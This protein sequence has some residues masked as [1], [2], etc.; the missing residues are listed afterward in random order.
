MKTKI[1][2]LAILAS[3]LMVACDD[4][5][6]VK[7]SLMYVSVKYPKGFEDKSPKMKMATFVLENVNTGEKTTR[8]VYHSP[9]SYFNVEDGI[10]NMSVEGKM[11][12]EV[13]AAEGGFVKKVADVRSKGENI[14]VVGGNFDLPMQFFLHNPSTGFVISEIY[15]TGSKTPDGK[16]Y[17]GDKFIEI[18][19]NSNETLYADGLCIAET[20]LNTAMSLNEYTPDIR[21]EATPVSSVY[22]IPGTGREHP[23]KPGETI[24]L[25]DIG[26]DH[27]TQNQNAID[28]SKADF[29]WYDKNDNY[30]DP[31]T[32]EVPNME[33][34]VSTSESVWSL[35]NRGYTGYVLFRPKTALTSEQF[36]AEYAYHYKYHFVMGDF[37]KWM[38]FDAWKAPNEW[39]I[40]A[41]QCST[42]SAFEWTV[43]SPELDLTW[44]H[45]GDSNDERYGHSVKRKIGSEE[46]GRIV[47]QDTNDSASDFIST[48]PNPSPG[49]VADHT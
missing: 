47:L 32:P 28:L 13:K 48:A 12:Y 18:Y 35:H 22:R 2:M 8:E 36:T 1:L 23:V 7:E 42:P 17:D 3:L 15:F 10:Y 21:K 43:M 29:E 20:E 46:D 34:M 6:L 49:K 45:S 39:I 44:T 9:A 31:D 27:R 38:E 4:D 5:D 25:C 14:S 41:V 11:E 19:N 26:I 16:Q 33:K 24:V 40:D 30:P 37:E